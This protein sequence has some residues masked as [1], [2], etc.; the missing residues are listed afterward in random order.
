M[1]GSLDSSTFA[2]SGG[3]EGSGERSLCFIETV[4]RAITNEVLPHAHQDQG[5]QSTALVG[6]S[7]LKDT[8]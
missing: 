5:L 2:C 4:A 1:E 3:W 8:I 6:G 7:H